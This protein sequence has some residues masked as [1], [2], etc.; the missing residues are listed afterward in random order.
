MGMGWRERM[1]DEKKPSLA[2]KVLEL[3][4]STGVV[5]VQHTG[6]ITLTLH[7]NQGGVTS[8]KICVTE[9]LK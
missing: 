9:T 5:K 6:E 8:S 7:V 3:L 1:T 2:K 4:L